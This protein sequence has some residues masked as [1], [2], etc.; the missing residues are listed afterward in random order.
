ML[1]AKATRNTKHGVLLTVD[2]W[3]EETGNLV[4]VYVIYYT[5]FIY[6]DSELIVLCFVKKQVTTVVFVSYV[7]CKLS[8]PIL[9]YS[10]TAVPV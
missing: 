8:R 5:A 10:D 3:N 6:T 9:N 1:V 2:N 4:K 7:D